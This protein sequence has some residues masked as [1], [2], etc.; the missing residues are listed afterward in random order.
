MVI[1]LAVKWKQHMSWAIKVW[2]LYGLK[3]EVKER[4]DFIDPE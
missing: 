1:E 2:E 3:E 4:K